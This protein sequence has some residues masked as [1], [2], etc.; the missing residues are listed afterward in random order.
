MIVKF[1]DYSD[2]V[3]GF[4]VIIKEKWRNSKNT[5][6]YFNWH[7]LIEIYYVVSGGIHLQCG[8]RTKWVYAG[9]TVFVNWCEPH[10]SLEFVDGTHHFIVQ[11][12]LRMLKASEL[13]NS[14]VRFVSFPGC[15]KEIQ[16]ITESIIKEFMSKKTG[17]RNAIIGSLFSLIG[18]MEREN[19]L[20]Y[21]IKIAET[22]ANEKLRLILGYIHTHF[23]SEI[24][25]SEL[26]GWVGVS[27][28]YICRLFKK[29]TGTTIIDYVNRLRFAEVVNLMVHGASVTDA[30]WQVGIKDYNYFS[31]L[32][33]KK[34]G[35]S[36]TQYRKTAMGI[37]T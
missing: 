13:N 3:D 14:C 15:N 24:T 26:A 12:D 36:P 22:G 9:E 33:K 10:K 29:T 32:F 7:E 35:M 16:S 19:L 21:G 8:G 6:C 30:S 27:E 4:P 28:S 17:Y 37:F 23:T 1:E 34:I 2:K 11:F 25:I 18:Y 31:R 20:T 5:G